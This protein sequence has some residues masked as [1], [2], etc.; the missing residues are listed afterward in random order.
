[1]PALCPSQQH[2]RRNKPLNEN[3]FHCI[4]LHCCFTHLY[5]YTS[6][7]ILAL[8]SKLSDVEG[9]VLGLVFFGVVCVMFSFC[10]GLVCGGVSCWVLGLFVGLFRGLVCFFFSVWVQLQEF[11]TQDIKQVTAQEK[12]D[13]SLNC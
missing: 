11:Q 4:F 10:L 8:H 6:K 13:N 3:N 9:P 5:T 1:M 12:K 7:V 2:T